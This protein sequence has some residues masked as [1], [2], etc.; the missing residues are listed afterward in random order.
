MQ[1]YE[2]RVEGHL[3]THWADWFDGLSITLEADGS[4]RITGPIS[5]QSALHGLLRKV[6]DLGLK[7]IS[8]SQ[9]PGPDCTRSK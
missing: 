5:D 9:V 2:I 8:V 3:D 4:T 7:L 6:R 1:S